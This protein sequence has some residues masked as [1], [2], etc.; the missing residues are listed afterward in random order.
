[1]TRSPLY[2]PYIR[3][4]LRIAGVD[5]RTPIADTL[6]VLY[7]ILTEIPHEVLTKLRDGLVTA[8]AIADPQRA[9]ETWGLTA[10]H[11]AMSAGL[12]QPEDR[13]PEGAITTNPSLRPRR[14][15]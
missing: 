15:T 9:R 11:Q 4:K 13:V 1:M 12:L 7:V 5:L 8:E 6:D 3:G 14:P 10:D 2:G